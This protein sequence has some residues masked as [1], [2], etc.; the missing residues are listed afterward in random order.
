MNRP[1]LGMALGCGS[2]YRYTLL[3]QSSRLLDPASG[4]RQTILCDPDNH[5]NLAAKLLQE[6]PAPDDREDSEVDIEVPMDLG[7]VF[8]PLDGESLRC[9]P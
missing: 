3:I 5:R 6:P 8:C 2:S 7:D 4:K 1:A 9:V